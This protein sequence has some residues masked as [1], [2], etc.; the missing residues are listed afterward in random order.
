[1]ENVGVIA[2]LSSE[3]QL[4]HPDVDAD[5]ERLVAEPSTQAYRAWLLRQYGF[6]APLEAALE[7]TPHFDQ[8]LEL[9]P[10]RKVPRLRSD[11]LALGVSQPTISAAPTCS[12]VPATFS[13]V[14]IAMGWL[15]SVE[16]S[17]LH[18]GSA[19]RQLARVLPGD[20]AF[21]SSYLKCY[22]GNV[23]VMWRSFA[24]AL[25]NVCR[26]PEDASELVLGAQEAFRYLRRWQQGG[27]RW[28][29]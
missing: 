2:R 23:G 24:N 3:T 12:S 25:D 26:R 20:V 19:F 11:L 18:H 9:R 15:Y 29:A 6:L 4:H 1:M 16:R 14:S 21:A 7:T 10:R 28:H 22:E 27:I 13:R 17:I 8:A 5:L